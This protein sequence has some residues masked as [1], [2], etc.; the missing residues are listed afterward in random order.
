MTTSFAQLL[1]RGT[2]HYCNLLDTAT[3][4]TLPNDD[5]DDDALSSPRC[6]GLTSDANILI[7]Y[8]RRAAQQYRFTY[9]APSPVESLIVRLCDLKQG[10]TQFGGTNTKQQQ[11]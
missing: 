8:A 10:Y 4:D 6:A 9:E 3:A 1:V 7:D 5:D 11:L 2:P